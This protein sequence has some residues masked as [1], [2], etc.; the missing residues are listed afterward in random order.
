MKQLGKWCDHDMTNY[1][2]NDRIM[3]KTVATDALDLK[4]HPIDN[5]CTENDRMNYF[6]IDYA[7]IQRFTEQ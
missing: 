7:T 4:F 2:T 1:K 3:K 6:S 5:N